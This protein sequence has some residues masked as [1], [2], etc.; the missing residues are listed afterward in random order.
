MDYLQQLFR[1]DEGAN[2]TSSPEVLWMEDQSEVEACR[3]HSS[4]CQ[5]GFLCP[6]LDVEGEGE[7]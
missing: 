2:T 6:L 4:I 5:K 7:R 3:G 1:E